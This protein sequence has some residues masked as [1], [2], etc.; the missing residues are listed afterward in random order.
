M[1]SRRAKSHVYPVQIFSPVTMKRK[2]LVKNVLMEW[3]SFCMSSFWGKW[4]DTG[5]M[6]FLSGTHMWSVH[7]TCYKL[8]LA[9]NFATCF[10][11]QSPSTKPEYLFTNYLTK[12][13]F[14]F[15]SE[16]LLYSP[17][18]LRIP[19]WKDPTFFILFGILAG[20]YMLKWPSLILIERK[21]IISYS[22]QG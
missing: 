1:V 19:E 8:T 16:F 17:G 10:L 18:Y 15:K 14:A 22:C 11:W 13:Y 20:D 2:Q 12:Y 6:C 9:V 4:F 3:I 21:K 7:Q 5:K